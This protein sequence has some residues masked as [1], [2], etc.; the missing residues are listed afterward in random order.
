MKTLIIFQ[1]VVELSK[2]KVAMCL[3]V[4]AFCDLSS[5]MSF[6]IIAEKLRISAKCAYICG[7]LSVAILREII[8]QLRSFESIL[9]GIGIFGYIRAITTVNQVILVSELCSKYYPQRFAAAYGMNMI[10]KG[11]AAISIGQ[12]LGYVRDITNDYT[13]CFYAQNSFLVFILIL[14][15][16]E[17]IFRR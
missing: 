16:A 15:T 11:V 9:I 10:F 5:R 12:F 14:W 2:Q 8:G 7:L 17:A 4:F 1:D 13:F 6:S 3:S